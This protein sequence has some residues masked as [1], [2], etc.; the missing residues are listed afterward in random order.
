MLTVLTRGMCRAGLLQTV[1][2]LLLMVIGVL[3]AGGT[4]L[5]TAVLLVALAM[6]LAP[7]GLFLL[8]AVRFR[9]FTPER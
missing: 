1:C 4:M 7:A 2:L 8:D 9:P 5:I 3:S 6:G